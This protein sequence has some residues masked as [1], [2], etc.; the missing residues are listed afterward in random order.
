MNELQLIKSN[1]QSCDLSTMQ[2]VMDL[3]S[4]GTY[5]VTIKRVTRRNSSPQR[6]Y[7]FGCVYP[8]LIPALLD[9]GWD[10]N[11]LGLNK[12]DHQLEEFN[13]FCESYFGGQIATNHHTGE[14]IHIPAQV[15]K[16]DTV[17]FS[18]FVEN[19]RNYA[20]EYLNIDIPEPD[21]DWRMNNKKG[22]K[23]GK[24]SYNE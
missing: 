10:A 18:S 24:I 1:G 12:P 13:H 19:I 21:K 11:D 7:L 16:M 8:L 2:K 14:I 9:A 23:H 6:G 22:D 17:Q 3:Q 4:E 20:S 15:S 5:L